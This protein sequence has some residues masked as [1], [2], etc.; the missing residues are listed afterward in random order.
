MSK[1]F[2]KPDLKL[3]LQATL[4]VDITGAISKSIIWRK[5]DNTEETKPAIVLDVTEGIIYRDFEDG[6]SM[7]G[8]WVWWGDVEFADGQHAAGEIN[9][10]MI[11]QEGV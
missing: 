7:V 11:H 1:I 9:T 4:E 6:D 3:R 5:P 8:E 2:H 10:L